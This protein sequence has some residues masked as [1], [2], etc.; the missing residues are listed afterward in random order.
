MEHPSASSFTARNEE[1]VTSTHYFTRI[2]NRDYNLSNN[3]TYY[4]SSDGSL[5]VSTFIGDPHSY[6]TTVGL[7]NN[8][9]ELLAVAKVSTPLLK[10]FDREA[11]IKVK[12]DY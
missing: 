11:L 5:K 10:S 7:Y 1:I 8:S 2:K 9:N 3:P 4:T 6:I 12:L